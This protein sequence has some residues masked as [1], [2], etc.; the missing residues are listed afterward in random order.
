MQGLSNAK[1]IG[2]GY[3]IVTVMIA[4]V[5]ILMQYW[6]AGLRELDRHADS[7]QPWPL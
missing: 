6:G 7:T 4:K 3:F 5:E 1:Q 2:S